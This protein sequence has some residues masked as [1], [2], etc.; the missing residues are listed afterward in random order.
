MIELF[1]DLPESLSPRMAWLREHGL[2]VV[3]GKDLMEDEPLVGIFR[4]E[5]LIAEG[6][7][8]AEALMKAAAK[9][10]VKLWWEVR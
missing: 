10:G 4:G 8:E 9:L 7:D 6:E 5:E 3:E 1:D 2:E